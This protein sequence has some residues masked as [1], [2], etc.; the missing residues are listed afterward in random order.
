MTVVLPPRVVAGDRVRLVSPAS[1]PSEED[2]A[3]SVR[4]LESLGFGR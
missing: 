1:Y 3:E 4:V 2:L